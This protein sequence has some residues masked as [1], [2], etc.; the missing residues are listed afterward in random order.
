[1]EKAPKLETSCNQCEDRGERRSEDGKGIQESSVEEV[2]AGPS[3]RLRRIAIGK[4][5][6]EG[7]T[8]RNKIPNQG[9][10]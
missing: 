3:R 8:D 9:I 5:G 2:N 6:A 1:M 4:E 7:I 10:V